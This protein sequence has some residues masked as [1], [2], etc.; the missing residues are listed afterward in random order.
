LKAQPRQCSV[1]CPFGLTETR[2][3]VRLGER[4]IDFLATAA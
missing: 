1:Q 4:V 3:P 2:V